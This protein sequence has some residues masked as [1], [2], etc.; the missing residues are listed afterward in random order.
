MEHCLES[1]LPR[2]A[3]PSY[4]SI[5]L[6]TGDTPARVRSRVDATACGLLLRQAALYAFDVEVHFLQLVVTHRLARSDAFLAAVVLDRAL[7][8]MQLA[9][10]DVLLLRGDQGRNVL[11]NS[12]VERRELDHSVLDA[13]PDA[14]RLP[15]AGDHFLRDL[16]VVRAPLMGCRGQMRTRAVLGHVGVI[17]K[18]V[19]ALL[20]RGLHDGSRVR[21][22]GDYVRTLRYQRV[23]RLAFASPAV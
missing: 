19:L 12:R 5:G 4:S 8:R 18:R 2:L 1:V 10:D 23:R 13:A 16:G 11:R 14:R 15:G 7:K 22:M 9:G 21:V 6:R 20:L 17:A 3:Q